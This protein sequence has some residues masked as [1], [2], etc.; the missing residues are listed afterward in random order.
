M[1]DKCITNRYFGRMK[2]GTS[3]K[4][5]SRAIRSFE[6]DD[7]V[8]LMLDAAQQDGFSLGFLCNTALRQFGRRI[9]KEELSK[10]GKQVSEW[11][12][13]A[14]ADSVEKFLRRMMKS[15]LLPD[16]EIEKIVSEIRVSQVPRGVRPAAHQPSSKRPSVDEEILDALEAAPESPL[17][18]YKRKR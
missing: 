13:N 4:K 10:Q 2:T 14:P 11:I 9:I 8:D 12:P 5:N 7:D 6:A 15:R 16:T 1:F 18:K 17:P 3:Q